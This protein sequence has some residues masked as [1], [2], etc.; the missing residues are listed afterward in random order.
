MLVY[1]CFGKF[2][3]HV[4]TYHEYENKFSTECV[5]Q[6]CKSSFKS[7]ESLRKHVQRHNGEICKF[8]AGKFNEAGCSWAA[9][10]AQIDMALLKRTMS[11]AAKML[12]QLTLVDQKKELLILW[13]I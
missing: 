3:R 5:A 2:C 12:N 4:S 13:P 1:L 8:V 6:T 10:D 11:T 7:V 9:S